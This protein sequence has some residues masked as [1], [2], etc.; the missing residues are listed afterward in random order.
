MLEFA[1]LNI[2]GKSNLMKIAIYGVGGVGGYFGAQLALNPDNEVHFIA[3]GQ[4]GDHIREHGLTI[5]T[6]EREYVVHPSS[7]VSTADAIG[8]C[9]L[10]LV[11]VKTWQLPS[12]MESLKKLVG[13]ET[14]VLPLLNGISAMDI[15]MNGIQGGHVLGGLC[16][17][18]AKIDGPGI[19]DVKGLEPTVV[20][21][22]MAGEKS[23]RV[24]NLQRVFEACGVAVEVPEDIMLAVWKK[25][26]FIA[27]LSG[28]G[29]FFGKAVGVLRTEQESRKMLELCLHEIQQLAEVKGI[30]LTKDHVEKTLAF[31]DS[32]DPEVTASMQRDIMAGRPSELEGQTGAIVKLA[33][34]NDVPIP[35]NQKIYNALLPKELRARQEN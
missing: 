15:I 3:R 23:D 5:R 2:G 28:V 9:D 30:G 12:I 4:H 17:I 14:L 13:D 29:A 26:M 22:E 21:G 24:L 33:K 10:V 11:S 31:I 18:V 8:I 7:T 6:I 1:G 19:I 25:F 32:L 16:R 35:T 34:E 27:A 20:F